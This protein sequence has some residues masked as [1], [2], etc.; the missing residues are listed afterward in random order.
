MTERL[1]L[2]RALRRAAAPALALLALLPFAGG[3]AWAQGDAFDFESVIERARTL[4]A[5]PYR[6]EQL[7]FTG[8]F[9][10]LDYDQYRDIR[11]RSGS[12]VWQDDG[13]PFEID[14]LPPGFFFDRPVEINVLENGVAR[15][16]P[17]TNDW[18]DFGPLV[19]PPDNPEAL[20]FSG[21]RLRTPINRPDV[22]DEFVVFQGASYFRAVAREQLYG[23]S[24]RALAIDTATEGGE[25]FPRFTHFWIETPTEESAGVIAYALLDSPSISGAYRFEMTPGQET[26]MDVESVLFARRDVAVP[27]IAP[28][29]SMFLFD[30]VNRER[31]DD[32]RDAVHDSDGLQIVNGHNERL[33]RS[34]GNPGTLQVSDFVDGNPVGFGLVQ[35]KRGFADYE[36]A[37]A[38]YEKRPSAWVQP[39]GDWG[40]GSVRLVEIPTDSEYDDNVVAFWKPAERFERGG[41]YRYAYRLVWTDYPPDDAPLMRVQ[42][43]R[44][45]ERVNIDRAGTFEIVVDF[46]V[47]DERGTDAA[48]EPR[49]QASAGEVANVSGRFLDG[50]DRYRMHFDYT[51][52]ETTLAEWRVQLVEEDGGVASETWLHRWTPG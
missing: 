34:L 46:S 5:E 20:S 7:E 13:S 37:E 15:T 11:F 47:P 48:L 19:E 22:L 3:Q 14:L 21:F 35:R 24:A 44:A 1:S 26:R 4:A 45:G 33:W 9:A 43:V 23:L 32:Y 6:D 40:E 42:E 10:E 29:T 12:P 49:V 16:V 18:F 17:Y 36:D 2:P 50:L 28:L 30:N 25:E 39:L 51:P 41:E 52:G 31:F 38:R 8:P 27:G